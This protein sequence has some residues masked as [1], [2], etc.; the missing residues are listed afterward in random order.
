MSLSERYQ[1]SRDLIDVQ[2]KIRHLDYCIALLESRRRAF[3]QL[4]AELKEKK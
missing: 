2:E 3:Q 4:E 1:N